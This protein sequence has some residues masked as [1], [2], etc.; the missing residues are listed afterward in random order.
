M[1]SESLAS[2]HDCILP[3]SHLNFQQQQAIKSWLGSILYIHVSIICTI[4]DQ[5]DGG[6]RRK[7]SEMMLED[8]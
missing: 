8:L 3:L 7:R 2:Y 4:I 6:E 5:S 1:Y